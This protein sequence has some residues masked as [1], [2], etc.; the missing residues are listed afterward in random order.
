MTRHKSYRLDNCG[1]TLIAQR[2]HCGP[3]NLRPRCC[4]KLR[5][6]VLL[7][8]T[9]VGARHKK[10]NLFFLIKWEE[11]SQRNNPNSEKTR[12]ATNFLASVG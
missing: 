8:A 4:S 6:K 10:L 2:H 3:T 11:A 5:G 9:K 12:D 7:T 1:L